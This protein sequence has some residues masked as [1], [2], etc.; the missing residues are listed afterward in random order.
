MHVGGMKGLLATTGLA[1]MVTSPLFQALNS[2]FPGTVFNAPVSSWGAAAFGAVI[3][4]FFGEAPPSRRR[5]FGEC[6][7]AMG[8]GV[9]IAVLAADGLDLD[10]ATNNASMFAMVCAGVVR[11]FMGPVIER[12]KRFIHE[13]NFSI[14]F[15]KKKEP[16]Q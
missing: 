3:S 7:A 12:G 8:F 1:G 9:A 5:L 13:T 16:P 15:L 2:L 4:L 6:T 14:P 10:W 11:W